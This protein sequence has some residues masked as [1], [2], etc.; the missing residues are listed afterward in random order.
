MPS[1][2]SAEQIFSEACDMQAAGRETYLKGACG[3]DLALRSK[4]E[5]LL[6]ADADAGSFL[7]SGT[8]DA[9]PDATIRKTAQR[10][11]PGCG[12]TGE[13]PASMDS[14]GMPLSRVPG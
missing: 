3:N 2:L 1:R 7:D 5:A 14:Y 10:P 4:V 11:A 8:K 12:A 13:A 6:K 9:D